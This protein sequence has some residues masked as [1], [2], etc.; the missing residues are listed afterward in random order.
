MDDF[1]R[2]FLVLCIVASFIGQA[3]IPDRSQKGFPL[4]W[5][6]L[7]ADLVAS[8]WRMAWGLTIL[9]DM[10]YELHEIIYR[11]DK[12]WACGAILA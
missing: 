6:R 1:G 12:T 8:P 3:L 4:G 9:A 7:L 2:D 5:G 10:Y 11:D